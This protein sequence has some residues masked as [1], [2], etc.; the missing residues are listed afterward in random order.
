[1]QMNNIK[2]IV[3]AEK[4]SPSLIPADKA[5]RPKLQNSVLVLPVVT[6]FHAFAKNPVKTLMS[7]VV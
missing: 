5:I 4:N 3:A 1:M 7:S 6:V 2:P